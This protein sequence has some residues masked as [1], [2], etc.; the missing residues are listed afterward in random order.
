MRHSETLNERLQA[1]QDSR[2][3]IEQVQGKLAERL[4]ADM[5]QAVS[6]LRDLVALGS[7]AITPATAASAVRRRRTAAEVSAPPGQRPGR[8]HVIGGTGTRP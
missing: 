5:N 6:L 4:G 8:D 7:R 3:I 2:V 1:A